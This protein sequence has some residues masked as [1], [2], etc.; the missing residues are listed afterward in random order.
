MGAMRMIRMNIRMIRITNLVIWTIVA[1]ILYRQVVPLANLVRSFPLNDF[2]VYIDGT[3]A[4]LNGEN[5]YGMKFFDRYNYPPAATLFFV[6]LAF[7]PIELSEWLFTG[8]SILS[9]WLVVNWT[10]K[11]LGW[12]SGRAKKWLIFALCLKMFPV[13]LTLALG[14]VNLIIL[15]LIVGSFYFYKVGE[16]RTFSRKVQPFEAISGILFGLATVIKL[17]PAPILIYFLLRKKWKVI[18]WSAA[19]MAVLTTAGGLIFGWDLT[20]NYFLSVLPGLMGEVTRETV[21][22]SYMN[23]SVTAF[24]ARMGIFGATNTFLRLVLS[25]GLLIFLIRSLLAWQGDSW[26]NFS[27]FWSFAVISTLFLPVFVWQHHYVF[28]MPG[29]IILLRAA[30][31]SKRILD[32]LAVGSSYGLLNFYFS[33]ANWLSGKNPL[34]ISHFLL[35]GLVIGIVMTGGF[36]LISGRRIL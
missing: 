6:P 36:G 24:L 21:N 25:G 35:T 2:S 33:D 15:A 8:V 10:L 20:K 31:K 7:L 19:T 4:A 22:A 30:V 14:Q 1:I 29:W 16:S 34:I 12:E 27:Q 5:P 17:T 13:K 26:F 32:W 9:V 18:K 3:K 23:Q 28:L 11:I